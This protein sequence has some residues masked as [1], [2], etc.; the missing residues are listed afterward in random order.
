MEIESEKDKLETI[1]LTPHFQDVSDDVLEPLAHHIEVVHIERDDAIWREGNSADRFTFVAEGC[2]KIAKWTNDDKRVALGLFSQGELIG[3]AAVFEGS[4]YPAEAVAVE[5]VTLLQ[6][7]RRHFLG[8]LRE[9]PEL[10]DAIVRHTMERNFELVERLHDL[11]VAS[12]E[13]RL[14]LLFE[15]LARSTGIRRPRDEGVIIDIPVSLSRSDLAQMINTRVETAIRKMSRWREEGW[16]E[17]TSEGFLIHDLESIQEVA[18]PPEV[19]F[20]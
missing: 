5:D 14:A 19:D 18:A 12:A 16:I 1:R 20:A 3:H 17:T 2:V 9:E 8:A 10:M 11:S 13:R 7:R 15:K 4:A 6:I